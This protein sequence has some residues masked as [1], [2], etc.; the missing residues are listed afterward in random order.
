MCYQVNIVLHGKHWT[1]SCHSPP[2]IVPTDCIQLRCATICESMPLVSYTHQEMCVKNMF[3]LIECPLSRLW[4]EI[5]AF[6]MHL[7]G[8]YQNC[9]TL[10]ELAD[11]KLYHPKIAQVVRY[12]AGIRYLTILLLCYICFVPLRASEAA[13]VGSCT[14]LRITGWVM[15]CVL[16]AVHLHNVA[17]TAQR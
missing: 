15:Y 10:S 1:T 8:W 7:L 3:P 12:L 5:H 16:Y 6:G 17:S 11:S 4:I 14:D 13:S 2:T 9:T